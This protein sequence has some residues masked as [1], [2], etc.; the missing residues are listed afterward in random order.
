MALMRH[1]TGK[2]PKDVKRDYLDIVLDDSDV[3]ALV[4]GQP[5]QIRVGLPLERQVEDTTFTIYRKQPA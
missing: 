5:V 4:A 2:D 1:P 3:A